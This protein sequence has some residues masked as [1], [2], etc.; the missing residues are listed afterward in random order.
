MDF[1]GERMDSP[2]Y[3]RQL[4][5]TPRII[6]VLPK[7]LLE[8]QN[9]TSIRDAMR[10]IPGISLQA[11]EGNPPGG[12]QLKIRGF[13]ARDDLN[14][15]GT[16]DLGNYFRDPFYVE[17]IEVVKG[18]NSAFG[19]RGSA[20]G[21][22]NFVTKKPLP[23]EYSRIETSVGTDDYR[24]ATVDLNRPV[25][26]NSAFRLNLM[27]HSSDIPGRDIVNERRHGIYGAYTWG[28]QE[29]TLITVDYLHTRQNN[30][31]DQGIPFD[32][33]GYTGAKAECDNP[34]NPQAGRV[35]NQRCGDGYYTGKIPSDLDYSN[36]YGHVDDYQN[37]DVDILGVALEHAFNDNVILRNSLRYSV[38]NNDSITSSP[39]IKIPSAFHGSGDWSAAEVQ[40]DL[41]PRDQTDEAIFNQTD[42]LLSFNTGGIRHDMVTGLEVGRANYENKRR[43]DVN[44]PR[45][46]LFNPERRTRP[47]APF[48]GTVHKFETQEVGVFVLDTMQFTPQWELNT[49]VR[50]DQVTAKASDK[51]WPDPISL[52]RTDREWSYSL[53]L[54]YKPVPN[55]SVYAATGTAFEISG[56]YD[57]NQVQLAGGAGSRI[58]DEDTFNVAPEKTQAYEL[59]VKWSVG[60]GLDINAAIFRTDKTDARTQGVG[61][62]DPSVL[63]GE[64]RVQGFEL[65]VAGRITP[66]WRLYGGYTYLDSEVRKAPPLDQ[67]LVGQD[68][69]G[70]PEHSFNVFSTYDFTPRFTAGGGLQY[71]SSQISAPQQE[72]TPRRRNVSID[73]YT[74]VD[75]YTTYRFTPQAQIR[76]NAFNILDE[77]YISQ[78][79]E[80][81]AQG[82]P[83]KGRHV[84]GT[85]RYDF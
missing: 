56:N 52:E 77:R 73:N 41:K 42:L 75:L 20:G 10:N 40:G 11:G 47:A 24:R 8:E 13:N 50:W 78:M 74:V 3:S 79:A 59:G 44:G 25:S 48:D 66:Q 67:F 5:D 16:R 32:R 12:D 70:T 46:D 19:G 23:S 72:E 84:I 28:F 57:R 21:T 35:G 63:E 71:V 38:V 62:G 83:G 34:T 14:V 36:Y 39:R 85:F 4:L 64:Q 37:I 29:N 30:I 1:R 69:G 58:A 53:G 68:L 49:G 54:V 7:D 15:N 33:E 9:V 2:R 60:H 81:G 31:P 18:P 65:L 43:P 17:Q 6:T 26:E 27:T 80:G 55:M 61:A 76:V 45:T 51:G 82:I 22:V